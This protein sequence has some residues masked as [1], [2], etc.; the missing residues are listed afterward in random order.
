MGS[1][2][3]PFPFASEYRFT[4]SVNV[5]QLLLFDLPQ[6]LI[7]VTTT[8]PGICHNLHT[9]GWQRCHS[10]F[11]KGRKFSGVKFMVFV[12]KWNNEIWSRMKYSLLVQNFAR[13]LFP[14]NIFLL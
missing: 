9:S 11:E 3:V 13:I 6:Y 4:T 10:V 12:R 14:S 5:E 7:P 2:I 1:R 8:W